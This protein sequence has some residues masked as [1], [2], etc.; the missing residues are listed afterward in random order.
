M[1]WV[2]FKIELYQSGNGLFCR[3]IDEIPVPEMTAF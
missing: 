3:V 2:I 1:D